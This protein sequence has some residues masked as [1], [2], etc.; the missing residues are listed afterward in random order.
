MRPHQDFWGRLGR[1]RAL[2]WFGTTSMSAWVV[3]N[4]VIARR[5]CAEHSGRDITGLLV[6]L[7]GW[8]AML[9][10]HVYTGILLRYARKHGGRL[11]TF[12]E[13]KK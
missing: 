4:F 7:A 3:W 11:P 12:P 8:S 2:F 6:G 9:T 10:F 5:V 1:S 13:V